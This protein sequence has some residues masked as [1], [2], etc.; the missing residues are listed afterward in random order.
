[1]YRGE[2][3]K[4]EWLIRVPLFGTTWTIVCQARLSMEFS[5]Q[6]YWSELPFPSPGDLANPGI[7]SRSPKLQ[8]DSLLTEPPRK[9]HNRGGICE[10]EV[11]DLGII[12]MGKKIQFLQLYIEN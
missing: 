5:R 4:C 8:A 7:E 10:F 12:Y 3:V 9:S 11:N 6:E 1:M 2:K